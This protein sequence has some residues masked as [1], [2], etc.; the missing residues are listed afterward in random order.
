MIKDSA[1]VFRKYDKVATSSK[2]GSNT[3][4]KSTPKSIKNENEVFQ[5]EDEN[6]KH[7]EEIIFA[8]TNPQIELD[9]ENKNKNHSKL[10]DPDPDGPTLKCE[11]SLDNI[12]SSIIRY[13]IKE[14]SFDDSP[15]LSAK[16]I[17]AKDEDNSSKFK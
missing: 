7:Q 13:E 14:L 17:E 10:S 1:T 12:N 8:R 11:A 2:Q 4:T 9:D 3:N 15:K 16:F 5:I 6:S